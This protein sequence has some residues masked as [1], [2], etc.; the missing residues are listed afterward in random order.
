M[1][2]IIHQYTLC[3]ADEQDLIRNATYIGI[4]ERKLSEIVGAD[5]QSTLNMSSNALGELSAA[6]ASTTSFSSF[7]P[8]GES[9]F[10]ARSSTPDS[11]HSPEHGLGFGRGQSSPMMTSSA[12]ITAASQLHGH[13]R[14]GSS[15][16]PSFAS[17]QPN[18]NSNVGIGSPSPL[19][20][21]QHNAS[22]TSLIPANSATTATL[23]HITS[24]RTLILSLDAK[25]G[26][27]EEKLEAQIAKATEESERLDRVRTEVVSV[28]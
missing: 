4:L 27:R 28:V 14:Q 5:W 22:V 3:F 1:R 15:P 25:M 7:L 26:E 24:L 18:F 23:A 2:A 16:S 11:L 21:H 13:R 10:L 8:Q 12:T 19:T 20:H 6:N 9:T 17:P